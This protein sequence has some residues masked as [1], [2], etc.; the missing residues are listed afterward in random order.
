M[1]IVVNVNDHNDVLII[2]KSAQINTAIL[3]DVICCCYGCCLIYFNCYIIIK[4]NYNK[5]V[6]EFVINTQ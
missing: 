4:L 3:R 1:H 5:L 6:Q 2:V